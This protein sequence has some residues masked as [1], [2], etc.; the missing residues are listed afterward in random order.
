MWA[1]TKAMAMAKASHAETVEVMKPA[2]PCLLLS[3]IDTMCHAFF[4]ADKCKH[5]WTCNLLLGCL[6]LHTPG[7]HAS[8]TALVKP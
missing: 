1:A 3:A 8:C 5:A 2:N 7:K 4:T 6:H